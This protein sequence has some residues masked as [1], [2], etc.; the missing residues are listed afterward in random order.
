MKVKEL[1]RLLFDAILKGDRAEEKRIYEKI[2]KKSLKHKK[3]H[4]IK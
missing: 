4:A 2:L 1:I 3:T